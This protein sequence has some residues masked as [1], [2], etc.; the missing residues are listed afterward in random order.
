MNVLSYFCV[1]FFAWSEICDL[2]KISVTRSLIILALFV[3]VGI[4]S[5]GLSLKTL[6]FAS[7]WLMAL[8]MQI[9]GRL[10][11]KHFPV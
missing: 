6:A 1:L 10:W 5:W 3:G 4:F 7:I 2:L 11:W 8:S 9:I